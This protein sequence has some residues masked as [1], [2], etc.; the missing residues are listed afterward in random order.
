MLLIKG[1]EQADQVYH[2]LNRGGFFDTARITCL[3]PLPQ[4]TIEARKKEVLG[5]IDLDVD[6][7]SNLF[8]ANRMPVNDL[9]RAISSD[10]IKNYGISM[11]TGLDIG[12]GYTGYNLNQILDPLI[13]NNVKWLQS[14]VHPQAVLAQG[15]LTSKYLTLNIDYLDLDESLQN[16]CFDTITGLSSLDATQ[17]LDTAISQIAN[18]LNHG[19]HLFHVQDVRPGLGA[20]FR[21]MARKNDFGPYRALIPKGAGDSCIMAFESNDGSLV[22]NGRG[23]EPVME[24]LKSELDRAINENPHMD[25]VDSYWVTARSFDCSPTSLHSFINHSNLALNGAKQPIPLHL[26]FGESRPFRQ[27]SAVVTVARRK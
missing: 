25:L 26:A 16:Y 18:H 7:A 12:S 10:A 8:T 20:N 13:T 14:D 21:A 6:T 11:Q 23:Y 19:G 3:D 17:F 1:R 27:V 2:V 4:D 22:L 9:L 15:R 5:I 24:N